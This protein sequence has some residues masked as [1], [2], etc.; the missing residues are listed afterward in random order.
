MQSSMKREYAALPKGGGVPR[1]SFDLSRNF[2]TTFNGGYLVPIYWNWFYPGDVVKGSVDAFV[3]MSSP[4]D[5][6]IMDN[7]KLT[8][9]AYAVPVRILWSNFRK[10]YGEQDDPGDSIDFTIPEYGSTA[11]TDTSTDTLAN[12]LMQYLEVPVQTAA[13]GGVDESDICALPFRAYNSIW[14]WH[15]RDQ[16]QQN[17]ADVPVDNGPD[18]AATYNVL[19]RGKRHDYFTSALP[20]PVRGD[21]VP[22][23][24]DVSS[25]AAVGANI[26]IYKADIEAFR[27]MDADAA[28]VDMSASSTA[29]SV[30]KMYTELLIND[31]RN[32]AAIQ[33]FLEK[34]NRYGTRFDEQIQSHFGVEFNDIRIAPLFL[35]GGSGYI[36]TSAIPNNSGSTGN[37]GDLASI[38][39]GSL[40]GANFSYA[41]DEPCILMVLANVSADLSY[42]QGLP[43]KH[44]YRTRYD[45]FWP[46]FTGLGDQSILMK[47]LYYGNDANDDTVFGYVPRYEELRTEINRITHELSSQ[48]PTNYDEWHL[49]EELGSLPALGDTWIKDSTPYARVL[50]VTS[51]RHFIGDFR[52]N[53]RA[54]RPLPLTGVPGLRRL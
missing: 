39:T 40:T 37:L 30:N 6:P 2:K 48:Y 20:A 45:L 42:Q 53:L 1:S 17:S 19:F 26:G 16:Q 13:Q 23:T 36:H 35:G 31:L 15:Y 28:N 32:T 49:A 38:A 21:Q 25:D 33:Q 43:R 51:I 9:H 41:F 10:F 47:E 24:M 27:L 50:Q 3:R 18:D 7:M 52:V 29:A 46:E 54:A 4:L 12:L 22:L 44:S 34:D 8:A 11:N 5:F 14:N